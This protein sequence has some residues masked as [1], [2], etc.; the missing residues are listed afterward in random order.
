MTR[1]FVIILGAA[2]LGG[3]GCSY[4]RSGRTTVADNQMASL[5]SV[6]TVQPI[7]VAGHRYEF[8]GTREEAQ[9]FM[10]KNREIT[11]TPEQEKI[12]LLA[13]DQKDGEGNPVVPAPCC[14]DK[15]AATCC[16]EC[17]LARTIWG[18]SKSLIVTGADATEVQEAVRAWTKALNP[19]GYA[20]VKNVDESACYAGKCNGPLNSDACGG[21]KENN[22]IF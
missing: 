19:S 20:G 12:R 3:V 7:Q 14:A 21:M 13:L 17:N 22:L 18:L 11:L 6:Q 5:V 15:T 8:K 9:S 2:F 1:I 16:C 10:D 4:D